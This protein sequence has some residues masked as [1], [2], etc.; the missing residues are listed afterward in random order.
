MRRAA[1]AAATAGA[2]EQDTATCAP[3]AP[4]ATADFGRLQAAFVEDSSIPDHSYCLPGVS[5]LKVWVMKNTGDRQWPEGTHLQYIS[6][7]VE[8]EAGTD[9]KVPVPL[10]QP[11]QSVPVAVRIVTPKT[12][13]HFVGNYRLTSPRGTAFGHRVWVALNVANKDL[14]TE[15]SVSG[16]EGVPDLRS[17]AP[18]AAPTPVASPPKAS[19]A[20]VARDLS[21]ALPLPKQ[22]SSPVPGENQ[23]AA[24]AVASPAPVQPVVAVQTA[25]VAAPSKPVEVKVA[26]PAPAPAPVAV[27]DKPKPAAAPAPVV[28]APAPASVAPFRYANE[29]NELSRMGFADIELNKYLL[30]NNNG[31]LQKVVEFRLTRYA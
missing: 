2:A 15:E 1:A 13:G 25:L 20:A 11:G 10:A 22:S 31:D 6:G 26:A 30:I 8:P 5:L 3:S 21:A 27:A 14:K 24:A 23:P 9:S 18:A 16:K 7:D 28:A 12:V 29:L 17:A 19:A 4:C